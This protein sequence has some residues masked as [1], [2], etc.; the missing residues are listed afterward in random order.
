[1]LAAMIAGSLLVALY[2][3]KGPDDT[4][5]FWIEETCFTNFM[6]WFYLSQWVFIFE[7]Y[8]TSVYIEKR[9][10]LSDEELETHSVTDLK[11]WRNT[12]AV[13]C[14]LLIASSVA[15]VVL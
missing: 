5:P 10:T 1:L 3:L 4:V 13:Y 9:L 11:H 12:N 6:F 14:S 8:K 7:H 15:A 2:T